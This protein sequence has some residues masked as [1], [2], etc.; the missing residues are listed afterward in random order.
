MK[1]LMNY[2]LFLSLLTLL[3]F[4]LHCTHRLHIFLLAGVGVQIIRKEVELHGIQPIDQIR[5]LRRAVM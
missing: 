4:H 3:H 1:L 5:G 2:V